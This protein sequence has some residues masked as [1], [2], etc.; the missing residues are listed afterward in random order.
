MTAA[1]ILLAINN[2][3]GIRIKTNIVNDLGEPFVGSGPLRLLES[4][5]R[6]KSTNRAA[7]EMNLSYVK[8]LRMLNRPGENLNRPLFI[9][10]RGGNWRGR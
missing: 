3:L 8:A 4:I 1:V 6:H 5:S 9:G 2:G 10:K 7:K